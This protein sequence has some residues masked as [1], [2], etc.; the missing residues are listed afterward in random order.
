MMITNN[1]QAFG[2]N[3][4]MWRRLQGVSA[5]SLAARAGISRNTLLNIE[6]GTG[7]TSLANV[8]SVLETLGIA[9]QVVKSSYPSETPLGRELIYRKVRNEK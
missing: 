5:T 3:I 9:E 8:F 4:Q 6:N 2:G 7:T 1:L